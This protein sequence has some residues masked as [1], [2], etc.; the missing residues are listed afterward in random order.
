MEW[1]D[2]KKLVEL[3]KE[4]TLG[5]LEYEDERFR[6]TLKGH[7]S[8]PNQFLTVSSQVAGQQQK[9]IN[10]V[11][12]PS[13]SLSETNSGKMITSPFVGTFYRQPAPDAPPYV[14]VGQIVSKGQILCI[15]EAMKLMNEIEADISGRVSGIFVENGRPVEF[16]EQ[17]FS[18]EPL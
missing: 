10:P 9:N 3:F 13:N 14:E 4:H 18:I 6:I 8:S 7:V 12:A 11:Q 15:I 5:E 17:L 1:D 2:I 16:G